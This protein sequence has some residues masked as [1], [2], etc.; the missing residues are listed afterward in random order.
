MV[1]QVRSLII[2]GLIT[3]A[4]IGGLGGAYAAGM[5]TQS[6]KVIAA[7]ANKTTGAMRLLAKGQRCNAQ[8]AALSWNK[9][10][11]RGLR[12]PTG[13]EGPIGPSGAAESCAD[14]GSC[15][16][17]EIGPGGGYVFYVDTA[18]EYSWHYLEAAPTDVMPAAEFCDDATA[19]IGVA[20]HSF[21]TAIG[22][23]AENTWII[24]NSNACTSGAAFSAVN[25][26]GPNFKTDWFLPSVLELRAM[27]FAL[28]DAGIGGLP[29]DGTHWSSNFYSPGSA[30]VIQMRTAEVAMATVPM[31][32]E[33]QIRPIRAF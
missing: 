29:I 11:P 6:N 21:S 26:R 10:G 27:K 2:G 23:G 32:Y 16:I 22:A 9:Q 8:E 12:G 20:G 28:Q 4:T 33:D 30:W 17:G 18:D 31:S 7:C 14:G 19:D 25:Y 5:H 13:D 1:L 15:E 3:A 24:L